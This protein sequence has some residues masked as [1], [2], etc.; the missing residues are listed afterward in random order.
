M[1]FRLSLLLTLF[2]CLLSSATKAQKTNIDSL[3]QL[4]KTELE[5]NN[6][7]EI[8]TVLG[9]E[10]LGINPAEGRY[11]LSRAIHLARENAFEDLEI[12]AYEALVPIIYSTNPD[13]A[14]RL[15]ERILAYRERHKDTIG[16][17]KII[18]Y[19]GIMFFEEGQHDLSL[20]TFNKGL[21]LGDKYID[22]KARIYT[23]MSQAQVDLGYFSEGIENYFKALEIYEQDDNAFGKGLTY[24]NIGIAYF[25]QKDFENALLYYQKSLEAYGETN[26]ELYALSTRTYLAN[27][28]L[29]L[30]QTDKAGKAYE[31]V[32]S[33]AAK[34]GDEKAII[35]AKSDLVFFYS[36][37]RPEKIELIEDLLAELAQ[38]KSLMTPF[39]LRQFHLAK[40]ARYQKNEQYSLAIRELEE[41]QK[42]DLSVQDFSSTYEDLKLAADLYQKTGR[43]QEAYQYLVAYKTINDSLVNQKNL[44][45]IK[46]KEA[47]LRYDQEN[48]VR[49]ESFRAEQALAQKNIRL[50]N[51][52][53]IG[54]VIALILVIGWGTTIYR[55]NRQGKQYAAQLEMDVFDRTKE[56]QKVNRN[57]EQVNYELRTFSYIASHDIKEPIRGIG[58][59]ASLIKN[60][61]SEE[62]Q[63]GLQANF[64][65]INLSTERL[66][67]L[68]EDFTSYTSMSHNEVVK[69]EPVN[70]TQLVANVIENFGDSLKKY[71]GKIMVSDLP[72]INSSSSLLYT[73]LKN[74]IEN[75]L[76]FNNAPNPT[77]KVSYQSNEQNHM[78][79]VADNGIGI[80]PA[81]RGEIFGMFKRLDSIGEYEGSGIGLAIVRL[82]VEKLNGDITVENNEGQGSR[83]IISMP[84][85]SS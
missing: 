75:G 17:L 74:L 79:I 84:I 31:E 73:S 12:N 23:N 3:Q 52:I 21:A 18:N 32:L 35:K 49:E 11:F 70:L 33:R 85:V 81:Y 62:L 65:I 36:K 80:D 50:R 15:N 25:S 47:E 51:A 63:A 72:V 44:A 46:L 6:E 68:V 53:A 58:A 38:N 4:L 56:L 43:Y 5:A 9:L 1:S 57:L 34:L 39:D 71:P 48:K 40:L 19:Q 10:Y 37:N 27:T 2:A 64:D 28:F 66:Y 78:L 76:K 67:N 55:A 83:F 30:G 22:I 61:L 60:H 82:S 54:L 77:V 42:L 8:L 69:L 29:A 59:H 13:S 20:E 41:V 16:I 14:H 24:N 45:E 26:N 7:I